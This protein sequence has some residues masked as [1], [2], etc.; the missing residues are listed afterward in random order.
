MRRGSLFAILCLKGLQLTEQ[1]PDKMS[2]E[3]V[4][5]FR[6][7]PIRFRR[8]SVTLIRATLEE[9]AFRTKIDR[10]NEG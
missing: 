9:I 5:G 10:S 7:V 6:H 1:T 3:S 2:N 4:P 8:P